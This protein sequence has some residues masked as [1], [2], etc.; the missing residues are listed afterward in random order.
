MGGRGGTSGLSPRAGGWTGNKYTGLDV[1]TKDG[2][3]T[4][5]YFTKSDGVNYYQRGIGGMSEP[6]PMNMSAMEFKRRIEAN[7]GTAKAL[8]N[9]DYERENK[10]YIEERKNRPD[11]ELGVGLKDNSA[12]RRT[13]R[14]NRII[15]RAMKRK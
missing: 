4:R 5:Y 9:A 14:K 12:Y 10:A 13:A 2:E 15:N 6:T 8:S 1:T 7:G 3:T 11:Y